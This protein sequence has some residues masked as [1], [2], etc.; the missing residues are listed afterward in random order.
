MFQRAGEV[1]TSERN[2][3]VVPESKAEQIAE[4]QSSETQ[5]FQS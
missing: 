2:A 1:H 3:P 4:S 5:K